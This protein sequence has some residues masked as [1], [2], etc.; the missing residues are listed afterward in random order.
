MNSADRFAERGYASSSSESSAISSNDVLRVAARIAELPVDDEH[1]VAQALIADHPQ[2]A[3]PH[4]FES[5][6]RVGP[7]AER[8]RDVIALG[9]ALGVDE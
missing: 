8:A 7:H 4:F 5:L 2:H 9:V 1:L 6:E 3:L